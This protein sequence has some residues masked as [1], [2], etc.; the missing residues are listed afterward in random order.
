MKEANEGNP[1]K[2]RLLI[3]G[4]V[5]GLVCAVCVFLYTEMVYAEA[6]SKR[7][8]A[9]QRYG[10]EQ[11]EVLVATRTI[12]PGETLSPSN[13][14]TKTWLSDLLPEDA[15]LSLDDAEGRQATSLILQGEVVS[16][17]RFN[18]ETKELDIPAGLV[19]IALPVDDVQAVGGSLSAGSKVDVYATGSKTTC[20]GRNLEVLA[21]SAGTDES[22]ARSK[23]TWVTLAVEPEKSQ[24]FVA[25]SQSMEIYFTL[26]SAK[27][28]ESPAPTS[29]D[30]DPADGSND[31]N[32]NTDPAATPSTASAATNRPTRSASTDD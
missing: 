1:M 31:T 5:C 3:C 16:N 24:E 29:T 12:H 14:T 13:C 32:A 11:V 27:P 8:E 26:P 21:T 2:K 10:G 20:L 19:A 15:L 4:I 22:A 23:I 7:N 25:A 28:A 18:N 9:L 30:N 6:D 17:S